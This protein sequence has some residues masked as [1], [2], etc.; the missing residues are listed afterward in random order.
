MPA[1]VR[2]CVSLANFSQVGET[3]LEVAPG[4]DAAEVSVVTVGAHDVLALPQSVVRDHLDRGADRADRAAFR[5][6]GLLD[7]LRLCGPEVLPEHGQE[8]HLVE[9]VV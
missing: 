4:L 9:T 2:T 6:E 7:L 1:A 8:L 3:G 5:S